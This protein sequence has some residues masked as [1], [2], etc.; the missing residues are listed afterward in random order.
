MDELQLP[1]GTI[2]ISVPSVAKGHE[3]VETFHAGGAQS[4]LVGMTEE[5]EIVVTVDPDEFFR[6]QGMTNGE[7]T[8]EITEN[9]VSTPRKRGQ[10]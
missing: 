1:K 6:L 2:V 5:G 4:A 8:I 9:G 3:L 10:A 7:T